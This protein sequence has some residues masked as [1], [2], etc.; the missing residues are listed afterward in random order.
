MSGRWSLLTAFT[1]PD[2]WTGVAG[3]LCALNAEAPVMESLLQA[4]T[5]EREGQRERRGSATALLFLDRC[6]ERN[7]LRT[8]PGLHVADP[9]LSAWSKDAMLHAKVALL[10]FGSDARAEIGRLRLIVSTGN[11]TTASLRQDIDMIWVA[12]LELA[13]ADAGQLQADL[14]GA[15][16]FFRRLIGRDTTG[17]RL[18][19]ELPA[20]ARWQE[21]LEHATAY[22]G[23]ERSRFIQS[24][25]EALLDQIAVRFAPKAGRWNWLCA[26]SGF[27]EQPSGRAPEV[28]PRIVQA[29]GSKLTG[30]AF[31][32]V[33]VNPGQA[34]ALAEQPPAAWTLCK[35]RPDENRAFMHAKFIVAARQHDKQLLDTTIY[36]GSGNLSKAGLLGKFRE[37]P[38]HARLEAGIVFNAG[39]QSEEAIRQQLP[40][41]TELSIDE[42][43]TLRAGEPEPQTESV[44]P[45]PVL[46]A[47]GESD[48]KNGGAVSLRLAKAEPEVVAELRLGETIVRVEIG[49]SEVPVTGFAE[50]YLEVRVAGAGPWT[51]VPV[52]GTDGSFARVCPTPGSIED[53]LSALLSFP[54]MPD[55]DDDP[56]REKDEQ[57]PSSHPPDGSASAAL[58]RYPV[59]D[60]MRLVEGL[61]GLATEASAQSERHVM[62]LIED[63][64]RLLREGL[65][66][67][68]RQRLIDLGVNFF[69][70]LL[71]L[72]GMPAI[73]TWTDFVDEI[74]AAW[75]LDALPELSHRGLRGLDKL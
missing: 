35:P 2:G 38:S 7:G 67:Q 8:I 22:D 41:W 29:L 3:L 23:P 20:A 37:Q 17:T 48:H 53:V 27:Y 64:R 68:E 43:L 50:P 56:E 24:M 62:G 71:S 57:V 9:L 72:P 1:P 21:L 4:F 5:G 74:A 12:D 6:T 32:R 52:I 30:T 28:L 65:L 10:G 11:W 36:L 63:A 19:Q 44:P 39:R 51:A 25:D 66:E 47:V 61:A 33:I 16:K 54:A 13:A 55:G 60:A 59:R 15:G 73:R 34:G 45:P 26:G 14:R 46:F 75:K 58:S 49:Q 70:P 31:R 42:C 18:F 69:A 40:D